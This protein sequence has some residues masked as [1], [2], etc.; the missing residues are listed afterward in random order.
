MR[1]PGPA[2]RAVTVVEDLAQPM[3]PCVEGGCLRRG[4]GGAAITLATQFRC[5]ECK[6]PICLRHAQQHRCEEGANDDG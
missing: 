4:D 1:W 3:R 5:S 6:K 2:G